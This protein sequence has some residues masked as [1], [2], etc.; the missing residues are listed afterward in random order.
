MTMEKLNVNAADIFHTRLVS[1][2]CMLELSIYLY[3]Y[4][5]LNICCCH[6]ILSRI[7]IW[8]LKCFEEDRRERTAVLDGRHNT[9]QLYPVHWT[10]TDASNSFVRYFPTN[11]TIV[12][13]RMIKFPKIQINTLLLLFMESVCGVWCLCGVWCVCSVCVVCGVCVVCVC[14]VCVCGVWER[15]RTVHT[16]LGYLDSW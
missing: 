15:E 1:K 9:M 4:I 13:I 10:T 6:E 8:F 16:C 14:V 2:V 12:K 11:L 3:I 7:R 5:W